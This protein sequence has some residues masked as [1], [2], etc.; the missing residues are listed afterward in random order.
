ME[1]KW[2]SKGVYGMLKNV[3][4]AKNLY[5]RGIRDDKVQEHNDLDGK[6]TEHWSNKEPVPARQELVNSGKF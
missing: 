3:V 4:N 6:I 1:R 5:L 2:M